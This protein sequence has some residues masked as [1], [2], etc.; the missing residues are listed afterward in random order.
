WLAGD[1][2]GIL[3]V[4]GPS[5]RRWVSFIF[6]TIV[7]VYIS[8]KVA[9]VTGTITEWIMG[10]QKKPTAVPAAAPIEMAPLVE[11]EK[12]AENGVAKDEEPQNGHTHEEQTLPAPVSSVRHLSFS[13]K[14]FR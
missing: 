14:L 6:G 9:N 5:N 7:F 13:E 10:S 1:T 11:G 12:P 8:W 2:K 4:I 3:V